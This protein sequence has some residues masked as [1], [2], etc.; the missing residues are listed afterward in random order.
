MADFVIKM[1][2]E[3]GNVLEQTES[4]Y[5][6]VEVRDRFAGLGYLVYWVKPVG[7]FT[8]AP[9][10]ATAVPLDA[11]RQIG[12]L[13]LQEMEPLERADADEHADEAVLF[14]VHALILSAHRSIRL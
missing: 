14:P 4:G 13:L 3:R 1:A 11:D 12:G 8:G 7:V 2:D 6:A 5:S 10:V 9:I